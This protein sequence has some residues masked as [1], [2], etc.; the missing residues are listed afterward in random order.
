[1][2]PLRTRCAVAIGTMLATVAIGS[3][4]APSAASPS[5]ASPP[6]ELVVPSAAYP[7]VQSAVDAARSGDRIAVRPGVYREQLTIRKNL[8]ITGAGAGK[9]TILAPAHLVTGS[10]GLNSIVTLDNAA[11]VKI[12]RLAVS[13]PG[14]GTCD[15]GALGAGIRVLG[16]AHLDLSHAAV[17]H[18]KDTPMAPCFRSAN[19]ILIGD[20][21]LIHS[22][23]CEEK[24]QVTAVWRTFSL[25]TP[26][27][28]K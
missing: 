23:G 27:A 1:M 4:A 7:T 13:G 28:T 22:L 12:S 3:A 2:N 11:S 9:T 26:D 20:P 21:G 8:T 17:S 16:G 25:D 18:I 19:S 14:S 24:R 15:E 5:A 6:P 10:D